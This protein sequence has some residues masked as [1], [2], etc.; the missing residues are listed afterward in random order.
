MAS[1][2]V[3]QLSMTSDITAR[4][5][6]FEAAREASALE[7]ILEP[8]ETPERSREGGP[9]T[10][11]GRACPNP[12]Q[13]MLGDVPPAPVPRDGG[14]TPRAQARAPCLVAQTF[15]TACTWSVLRWPLCSGIEDAQMHW[16]GVVSRTCFTGWGTSGAS[17][18]LER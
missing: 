14:E 1:S 15:H 16:L 10:Y 12:A 4:E 13:L 9:R 11:F 5:A 17:D 6:S 18:G 2:T 8:G 7:T 3:A